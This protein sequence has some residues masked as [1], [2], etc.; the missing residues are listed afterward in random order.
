MKTEGVIKSLRIILFILTVS[1][2]LAGLV[3]VVYADQEG[4]DQERVCRES[5]EKV[6][7]STGGI[8][9]FSQVEDFAR[10]IFACYGTGPRPDWVLRKCDDL[11]SQVSRA[12]SKAVLIE[13]CYPKY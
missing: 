9:Y 3:S 2:I 11:I 13:A 7:S 6:G 10:L 8:K 12:R 4:A 5:I 1:I